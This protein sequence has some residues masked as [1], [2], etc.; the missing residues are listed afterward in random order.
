MDSRK[1]SFVVATLGALTAL[2]A[3]A[4]AGVSG[5]NIANIAL[6]NVGKGACSTNSS[7]GSAFDSSCTGNGGQPE[8]WCA[9]FAR[10]VWNAAGVNAGSLDAAAG[11]FYVY[12]QNN[13]TLHDSPSVGDAVVFDWHGDGTADHVALVSQV[14]GDGTIETVSGDWN[15]DSGSEAEFS[16]TSHVV[17]NDPAYACPV[18]AS[19]DVMGM[20]ISGFISPVGEAPPDYAAAFVSQSFPYASTTLTMFAGQTIPSYIELSNTGAKAWGAS[21]H[22][23]TT[24]PRDRTSAFADS[25]W[26]SP[27]RPSGVSGSVAPGASYKFT[28]DLHAPATPGTYLEYFN[29]VEDGVAWFS[30]EGGP[31]DSDLEANIVVVPGVRGSLDGAACDAIAGWAQDQASPDTA[32]YTDLYFDAPAGEPGSGSMRI[33]AGNARADL[34][35]AIGSCDHGFSVPVPA[36]LLDGKAHTVYA[37]GIASDS[38]GPNELVGGAPKSFTCAAAVPPYTAHTGVKRHVANSTSFSA[39]SFASLDIDAETPAQVIAYPTSAPL[40]EAPTVLL[41]SGAPS[42]WV[43][44]GNVRRHVVDPTSL[45]AWKLTVTTTT[46]AKV[47]AYAQGADWPKAPFLV[48]AIGDPAVYVLDVPPETARADAGVVLDASGPGETVDAETPGAH[49]DS[50]T[51][52]DGDGGVAP[53]GDGGADGGGASD[54]SDGGCAVSRTGAGSGSVGWLAV[55]GLAG[56][57]VQRRRR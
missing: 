43:I 29:L 34:C 31:V 47:D 32:I 46:A 49:A 15:G 22:L 18:G 25:T 6:A 51:Q 4:W 48:Q 24:E 9:D 57:F 28:F 33:V 11:S 35:T 7:G 30:D 12:G 36:A 1:T 56:L 13:G 27:S 39:W 52:A 37:Y 26:L 40:P 16:S 2:S 42:V 23:G 19:P 54:A 50:G 55:V 20:T 8:Y 10:W 3:T 45:A 14:N 41:A 44:D 53:A 38:E 21:T 17:L 5:Q